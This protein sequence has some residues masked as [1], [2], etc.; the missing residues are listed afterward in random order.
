VI[1]AQDCEL[2]A[3][4]DNELVLY[5]TIKSAGVLEEARRTAVDAAV[6][7]LGGSIRW[8]VSIR[9]QRTYGLL[10]FGAD[11]GAFA[12]DGF[13][14]HDGPVIAL[15]VFPAVPEAL[16]FVG[17]ALNGA[18]RPAGIVSYEACNGG[19]VVEWDPQR[20]QAGVVIGAIDAELRRFNSGRTAELLTPLPPELTARI[21]AEALRTP[22]LTADRILEELIERAGLH[23]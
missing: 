19:L 17:D 5:R 16:P 20:T 12:F 4:N 8:H 22:Q 2:L 15:A 7:G 9:A 1:Y 6:G 18:G 10:A 23:A 13:A 21:A 14:V 11:I 3:P